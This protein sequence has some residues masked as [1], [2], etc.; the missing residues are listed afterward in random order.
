MIQINLLSAT[1]VTL[2]GL[3]LAVAPLAQAQTA[4]QSRLPVVEL[5]AGMHI[6]QAELAVT[7]SQQATGMMWRTEMPGNEGMLFVNSD[8]QIRCF[9]MKN[10]LIP[11]TIA[12]LTADGTIINLADMQPRSEQSH[13]SAKP[14]RFALEM[15]QG[16]FAKR[17][18]QAGFQLTG[19][20]FGT[21]K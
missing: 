16:W 8:D 1:R 20:P 7:P 17:G 10:T 2:F 9:W 18:I 14:A 5:R 15:R 12:Y 21:P 3:V 6:I 4:P 19:K 11:L 13:C